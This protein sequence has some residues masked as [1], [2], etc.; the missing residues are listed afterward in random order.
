MA[1]L[2]RGLR[3]FRRRKG[4]GRRRVG[5]KR[6]MGGGVGGISRKSLGLEWGLFR[7]LIVKGRL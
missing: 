3:K 4:G 6:G 5:I 2:R 1:L 7:G